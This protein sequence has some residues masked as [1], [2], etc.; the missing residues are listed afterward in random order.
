[1]YLCLRHC[2]SAGG[3]FGLRISRQR[4]RREATQGANGERESQKHSSAR[5]AVDVFHLRAPFYRN[6]VELL[7]VPFGP[8]FISSLTQPAESCD[9]LTLIEINNSH[10]PF[11]ISC[12]QLSGVSACVT[13]THTHTHPR[14]HLHT[15]TGVHPNKPSRPTQTHTCPAH[16]HT[17]LTHTSMCL[18]IDASECV[19]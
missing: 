19:G 6:P 10:R 14:S 2:G 16:A 17:L 9:L 18:V 12:R 1:M 7:R 13:H 5:R 15:S 11:N 8:M 3:A 4:F